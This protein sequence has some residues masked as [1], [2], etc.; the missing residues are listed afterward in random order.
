MAADDV[1]KAIGRVALEGPVNGLIEIGG[2]ERFTL[3]ALIRR[4][5][6]AR[7]DPRDVVID[8]QATYFG[9]S[10]E[11]L[12]LCPADGARLGEIRFDDWLRTLQPTVVSR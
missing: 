3:E 12:T 2:P 7:R 6:A 4:Y 1:A 8:P 5:V 11:E 9:I 10:L